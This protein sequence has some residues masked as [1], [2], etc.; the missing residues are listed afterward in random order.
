MLMFNCYSCGQKFKI[1]NENLY[2]KIAIQCLNCD[3]PLPHEAVE[4]LRR[5]GEA[6]LDLIDVLYDKNTHSNAWGVSIQETEESIPKHPNAGFFKNIYE[7]GS[8]WNHRKE[9]IK[10]IDFDDEDMPF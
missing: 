7:R 6:Y 8:Y 9:P 1:A 2:N 5:Y 3:N 10:P 4:A